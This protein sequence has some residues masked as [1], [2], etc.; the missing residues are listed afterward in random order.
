[1]ESKVRHLIGN[2][3]R[4]QHITLAHVNPESYPHSDPEPGKVCT[5]WF[6]G[7][8]FKK[9]ENLNVDLTYDIHSFTNSGKFL[10]EFF[11]FLFYFYYFFLHI[12]INSFS[13]I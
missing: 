9:T 8:V 13:L 11:I 4:N 6:I 2:L 7:L 5:M 10:L 3:E 1:M 12:K